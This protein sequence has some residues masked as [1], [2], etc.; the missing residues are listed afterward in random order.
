LNT[1][2]I[3][4]PSLT[5]ILTLMTTLCGRCRRDWTLDGEYI[6]MSLAD[7]E[8]QAADEGCAFCTL[9]WTELEGDLGL[10]PLLS[11]AF[12]ALE[13]SGEISFQIS[14][15]LGELCYYTENLGEIVLRRIRVAARPSE[16]PL[17]LFK[18]ELT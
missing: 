4:R 8:K 9:L 3:Y 14:K 16:Y 1:T 17:S 13:R 2:T 10:P 6:S 12:S 18:L 5:V 7:L 15:P 11:R